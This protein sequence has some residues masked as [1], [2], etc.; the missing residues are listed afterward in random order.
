MI[1]RRIERLLPPAGKFVD[2]DGARLHYVERGSG[3]PVVMIHGL[4]GV[5]QN[6]THSLVDRVAQD[7]RV[8]AVDRPGAG[9]SAR[10]PGASAGL[11][12]QAAT[13]A[14]FI[15]ELRIE[16]P[17]IVGHSLGGAVALALALDFPG[18]P[19][20][21][22]LIAPVTQPEPR[23]PK[24][25]R[26]LEIASPLIRRLIAHTVA[27]PMAMRWGEEAVRL[28]FTPEAVPSDFAT[29]GGAL[30]GLRPSQFYHA[31]SDMMSA[32]RDMPLL[33]Q[34][35]AELQL[36]V[37]VLFGT[38]DAVLDYRRHAEALRTQ[39][40]HA[41]IK[42]VPGGHMLPITQPGLTAGVILSACVSS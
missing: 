7:A 25:F 16:R 24:P 17:L 22:A 4:A 21:L 33:V 14:S 34:R 32:R 30:L 10:H 15:Q 41:E 23:S 40:P 35:Y 18:L 1:S 5:L 20:A 31:S 12:A 42:L 29:A 38:E 28:I 3:E 13:I 37:G 27:V 39:I 36:P 2:V 26:G 6:F 11:F 19:R 8:I 9:Y